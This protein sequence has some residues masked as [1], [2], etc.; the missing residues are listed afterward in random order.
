LKPEDRAARHDLRKAAFMRPGES[1]KRGLEGDAV[2][3]RR[4][5][6]AQCRSSVS[7]MEK[8]GKLSI[9]RLITRVGPPSS[10]FAASRKI[11]FEIEIIDFLHPPRHAMARFASGC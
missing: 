8:N 9:L 1:I 11:F 4:G 3:S 6:L 10:I 5:V 7:L 2:Y